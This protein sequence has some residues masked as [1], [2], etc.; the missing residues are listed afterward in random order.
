VHTV[1][2]DALL[3]TQEIQQVD[4]DLIEADVEALFTT[5]AVNSAAIDRAT[6]TVVVMAEN[7]AS[8]VINSLGFN[9]ILFQN[10]VIDNLGTFSSHQFTA[11]RDGLYRGQPQDNRP[12]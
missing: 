8:Q 10:E 9:Q 3:T 6:N 11:P 5:Q 4:I 2:I 7:N 12:S 1:N